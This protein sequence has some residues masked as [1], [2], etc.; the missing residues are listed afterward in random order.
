MN[1]TPSEH[2]PRRVLLHVGVPKTGTSFMQHWLL[3]HREALLDQGICYPADRFD[4]HFLAALDLMELTWGGLE[5]QAVG[6][7]DRLAERARS[8]AGTVIVSHEILAY[9][10]TEQA[11]RAVASFGDDAEVHVVVSA[12]DLARQIPAE[13][14][15]NVKHRRTI[16]YH[17][18]LAKITDP[19]RRGELAS[20]FWG[21]QE[22]PDVLDRWGHEL[23]AD[24][25]HL[26]TV[27]RP[28]APPDLLWRRFACVFGL[29]S[30]AFDPDL[31]GSA[32]A[33]ANPSLGVP[34]SALLRRVNV[35]VNSADLANADYRQFVRELL[36]HRTLATR[37][38]SARL[39]LPE[40][41]R[42]WVEE[43]SRAWVEVLSDKGYHVVGSLDELLPAPVGAFIDPDAADEA[44]V[45]GAAVLA[46]DALVSEAARLQQAERRLR[47][48]LAAALAE[49]DRARG[50]IYRVKRRLVRYADRNRAAALALAA[51]RWVRGKSS[52]S[53]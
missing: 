40:D 47:A 35:R 50:A 43:V 49:L 3:A 13:W 34:E 45:N 27:P 28:G 51:Y 53:A 9:A 10:S 7:W 23:P 52:R 39:S 31:N 30:D 2:V 36:A 4:E 1:G 14:Q 5:K 19:R 11:R 32:Q 6:A 26:V 21:V 41:R 18:F 48:E 33:R 12:R 38:G 25:V 29:D 42:G 17:D 15:E 22:V 46:I 37:T 24:R 44:A 20:W 16:G 8:F